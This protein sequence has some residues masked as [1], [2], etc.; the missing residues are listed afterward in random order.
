M[1]GISKSL[2]LLERMWSLSLD[3]QYSYP[4]S[5][6][7]R[8]LSGCLEAKCANLRTLKLGFKWCK[9]DLRKVNNLFSSIQQTS[10]Y[11]SVLKL[12]LSF[13]ELGGKG[14]GC[15]FER[16]ST[17][18]GLKLLNIDVTMNDI[19]S[20]GLLKASSYLP[21]FSKTLDSLTLKLK[22][23]KIEDSGFC[24]FVR[25]IAKLN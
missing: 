4:S 10:E 7:W 23:N 15:L 25:G 8:L 12:D 6:S 22:M 16:L 24:P 17:M 21:R 3:M 19:G 11:L 1:Q 2:N 18:R 20:E 9:V 5:K 13:N 14:F